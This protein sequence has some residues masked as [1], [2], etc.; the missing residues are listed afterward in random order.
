METICCQEYK[1]CTQK[2]KIASSNIEYVQFIVNWEEH[3]HGL[4]VL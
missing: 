4:D 2:I 1:M 3:Q